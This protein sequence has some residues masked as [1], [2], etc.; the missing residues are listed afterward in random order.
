MARKLI[1][2]GVLLVAAVV[3]GPPLGARDRPKKVVGTFHEIHLGA[4]KVPLPDVQQDDGI[5]CGAA[6][7]MSVCHYYGV[8]PKDLAAFK[9]LVGTTEEGTDYNEILK[10]AGKLGLAAERHLNMTPADLKPY[11][12]RVI[13]VICSIQAW[14]GPR[15]DYTKSG[16]GHYVVAIGYAGDTFYFMDPYTNH[17]GRAPANPRYGCLSKDELVKRWHEVES[18]TEDFTGLGL[19]IHPGT[20]ENPAPLLKSREIE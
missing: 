20:K 2:L 4:I 7:T 18:P 10:A 11:L 19:V 14:G 3:T 5:S 8:G 15:A 17:G 9:R 16:N 1:A 13:P 12:D 6:V